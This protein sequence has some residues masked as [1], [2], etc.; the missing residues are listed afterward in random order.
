MRAR[1]HAYLI[2]LDL[3]NQMIVDDEQVYTRIT[4]KQ[5]KHSRY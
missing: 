1:Y 5:H 2:V 4:L 3:V